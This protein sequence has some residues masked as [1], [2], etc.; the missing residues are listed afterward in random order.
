MT[1]AGTASWGR[2]GGRG[3]TSIESDNPGRDARSTPPHTVPFRMGHLG[4]RWA[5]GQRRDRTFRSGS[6]SCGGGSRRG[7][8]RGVRLA[9]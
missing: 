2:G 6:G 4:R 7:P 1:E 9:G 3:A 5:R 8:V